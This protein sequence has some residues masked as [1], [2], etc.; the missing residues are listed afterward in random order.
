M[1]PAIF[2]F[3][4]LFPFISRGFTT[5]INIADSPGLSNG[6]NAGGQKHLARVG[7]TVIALALAGNFQQIYRSIDS[8]VNWTRIDTGGA[9][10]GSLVQDEKYIYHIYGSGDN[11]MMVR[12]GANDATIPAPVVIFTDPRLSDT[13]TGIYQSTTA[14][15]DS[16]GRIYIALHWNNG[17]GGGADSMYC[18]VSDTGVANWELHLVRQGSGGPGDQ[19]YTDPSIQVAPDNTVYLSYST[20][21]EPDSNDQMSRLATSTDHGITWND[22]PISFNTWSIYNTHVLPTSNDELYIFAQAG[23][24]GP[25][26][27]FGPVFIKS[28]DS[29]NTWSPWT[30]IYPETPNS[31]IYW[32]ADPSAA[33]AANGDIYLAVRS[34]TAPVT[35]S[36]YYSRLFR[37]Q[38]GGNTWDTIFYYYE[39]EAHNSVNGM[40]I[41][42]SLRY[43]TFFNGGG[44]IE[45][46]WMQDVGTST[47]TYFHKEAMNI[48]NWP[49]SSSCIEAWRL[50]NTSAWST[51]INNSQTR[52]L[53]Y[54]D[55]NNCG[56]TNAKPATTETQ[57]CV[58]T[59]NLANFLQLTT[60]WLKTT[61][62]TADVNHDGKV[63]SRDLGIM[64][65]NW[66]N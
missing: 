58:I 45:Y 62:S 53:T 19:S 29:G 33:L 59:Y 2:L 44:P 1:F 40:M 36:D 48:Y 37:S 8:G 46:N 57:S 47:P 60:N 27:I 54:V 4:L 25:E 41:K 14:T 6:H 66:Q 35:N 16:E 28:T 39:D 17:I 10:S 15:I 42:S 3:V 11:V 34:S 38:D 50:T 51:C 18:L 12:F 65:S 21:N 61:T 52:T 26:N 24:N 64:M 56:T 13:G 22:Q 5:N 31:P 43:Q 20:W 7:D 9:A 49:N 30:E 55:D 32:Y 63:D 23:G